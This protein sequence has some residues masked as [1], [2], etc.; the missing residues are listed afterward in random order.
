MNPGGI[1]AVLHSFGSNGT[2][3]GANPFAGLIQ[4][5]DGHFYGTTIGAGANLQGTVFKF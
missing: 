4:A 3:D 1:E 5:S 2:D